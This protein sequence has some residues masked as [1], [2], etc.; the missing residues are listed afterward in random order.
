[1][2]NNKKMFVRI[3]VVIILILA[4][5]CVILPFIQK[6]R[7]NAQKEAE[8]QSLQD[9]PAAKYC[10]DNGW[11]VEIV[12]GE[13]SE[14]YWL[15][16]FEDE[17]ECELLEYFR[18]ECTP[19]NEENQDLY[20]SDWSDC[21]EDEWD[22]EDI[23]SWIDDINNM[24]LD[25]PMRE[26]WDEDNFDEDADFDELYNIFENEFSDSDDKK[27]KVEGWNSKWWENGDDQLS[28]ACEW[29]WWSVLWGKCF[30]P[31]WIEIIF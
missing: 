9:S 14:V 10:E 15:C 31:S 24:D 3:F 16:H 30:L 17:S 26:S 1:M 23:G 28:V 6:N 27:N 4:G 12:A 8:I 13:W 7:L 22:D 11:T 18:W 19:E 5:V 21:D 25:E 20:C 29:I 2:K